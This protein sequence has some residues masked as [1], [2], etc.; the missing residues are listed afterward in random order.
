MSTT[1]GTE[2]WIQKVTKSAMDNRNN[3]LNP[4]HPAYW[5]SRTMVKPA[6][7]NAAVAAVAAAVIGAAAAAATIWAVRRIL[8]LNKEK[9]KEEDNEY[10][11]VLPEGLVE[12]EA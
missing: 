8:D 4:C 5:S 3:Q 11:E 2:A 1:I 10:L 9:A 12:E 7:P 6:Q